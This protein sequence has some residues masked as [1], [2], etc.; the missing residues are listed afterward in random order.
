MARSKHAA[1]YTLRSD[2]RYQGY[3]RDQNGVRHTICDRDPERLYERIAE[4]EAPQAPTFRVIAEAWHDKHWDEITEGTKS[5]YAAP[6]RRA[7]DEFGDRA[8]GEIQPFEISAH[9]LRLK[10]QRYS[11]KTIGMQKTVYK[12]I[13][14]NAII[15][16]EFSAYVKTNPVLLVPMPSSLPKPKKREAPEDEIVRLI[17]EKA[18]TT[19]FGLF[20]LFLMATG[21]RRGEALGIQWRDVDFRTG[22]ISCS[23]SVSHRGGT[24]KI[25]TP[26][27]EA[28]TRKV[29]I[30]P[31]L[32]RLL[33]R[34]ADA[35]ADDFV[36]YG[37]DP[38]KPMPLSTYN[39]RWR[40]YCIDMGFVEDTPEERISKQGKRYIVHNYKPTLTAHNFRH[41]YA[42]LLF[43]AKVDEYTAQRLIGHANIETTH[44]IY[45]HLRNKQKESSVDML[46]A[47]VAAD[48]ASE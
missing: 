29:P 9:L 7:L 40:H 21:F 35:A 18:G 34:P 45:T 33:K 14:E 38:K 37:E 36:F 41:G 17:R 39:R 47:H 25:S 8:A 28:G 16:R 23:K 48:L 22:W 4:K 27:T 19:Y 11:A 10:N 20:A 31:D 24:A 46:I 15:T 2:G 3:W 12:Q 44:A 43:E 5:C 42:T 13:Y 32:A 30:L 1:L 6:Y 26:K